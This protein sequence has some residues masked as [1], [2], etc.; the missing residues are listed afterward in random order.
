MTKKIKSLYRF[1]CYFV[2]DTSFWNLLFNKLNRLLKVNDGCEVR[3]PKTLNDFI[4]HS[5]VYHRDQR[6]TVLANKYLANCFVSSRIGESFVPEI[7]HHYHDVKD[8]SKSVL[9]KL[10]RFVIKTTH[11]SSGAILAE[12]FKALPVVDAKNTM[13]LSAPEFNCNDISL[14][15]HNYR[16]TI[17]FLSNQ[18]S[19]NH[20][21]HTREWQY[22]DQVASILVEELLLLNG[23][24]PNDV[25]IHCRYGVPFLIYCSVDRIG[26]N[27][28][29][30]YDRDWL[31]VQG[32]WG[33][34]GGEKKFIGEDISKPLWY[35]E[36]DKICKSL[37]SDI[38]YVRLDFYDMGSYPVFGEF[39]F[40]HGSGWE[41]IKP[42]ALE[43]ELVASWKY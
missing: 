12:S 10:E 20:F 31:P 18:M 15:D 35:S 13:E 33:I 25:K 4:L 21:Y 28:R 42:K 5:K 29:K 27:Y 38:P 8:I 14:L 26:S 19:R 17:K 22:K 41:S 3:N 36:I 40:H 6:Y 39:T 30:L 7:Y 11:D 37:A 9:A 2:P 43:V 32:S 1:F 34:K 23:A 24:P 16:R